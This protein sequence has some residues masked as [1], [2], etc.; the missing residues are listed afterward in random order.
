MI[1]IIA[2]YHT[3]TTFS[4][5]VNTI[6]ENV[7]RGIE[8]GLREIAITDHS[9]GH[10]GF[11]IKK[12]NLKEMRRIVDEMNLKYSQIVV[13]LGL[14]ANLLGL[15]GTVD[16]D[17]ESMSM[18]DFLLVGYHFGSKPKVFFRDMGMHISNLLSSKSKFFYEKAK[19]MNTNGF[20]KAIEK[21]KIFA[22]THPGAKGPI[23]VKKISE[24]AA[25]KGVY[26]EI[27]NNH[28][29]L[30]VDDIKIAC[31]TGVKFIVSSDAHSVSEI[32][33]FD[34]AIKR[35]LEAGLKVEQII[36]AREE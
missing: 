21:Y 18:L 1:K 2:D 13:K 12:K 34:N 16:I 11:G 19:I 33:V 31:E 36:N 6:E 28:G 25:K 8:L 4:H 15:D 27:N 14:E 17:D 29:K 7:I 20:L 3:H 23:N 35:V 5:G 10:L 30:S 9:Y 24:A 26:L 22:I 32:G